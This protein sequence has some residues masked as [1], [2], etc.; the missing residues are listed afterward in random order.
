MDSLASTSEFSFWDVHTHPSQ[1][2]LSA[3]A[4][5]SCGYTDSLAVP[6]YRSL[7]IHPWFLTDGNYEDQWLWLGQ[8]VH[9]PGVVAIG[10]VGLDKCADT[11]IDLQL[12]MFRQVVV[13][14]ERCALP[15]ILHV[16]RASNEI[17]RLRKE[18][19]A[20]M[21]WV[22]HGFRGGRQLAEDYLR[23][24][25]YLSFGE[26]YRADALRTVPAERLLLE[27]DESSS[28]IETV[29]RQVAKDRQLS[30]ESLQTS[31]E[32]NI[33]KLFFEGNSCIFK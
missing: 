11:S 25:L 20:R 22:I 4:I 9:A 27:T 24:G 7:S 21:P 1:M 10:E 26:H 29:Y 31:V 18:L 17:I 12:R 5:Y 33:K 16:V 23:H 8:R 30:L 2:A 15:L 14:S 28:S 3:R 13:L 32:Q 6:C 19:D